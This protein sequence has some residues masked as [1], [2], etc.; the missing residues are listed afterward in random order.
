MVRRLVRADDLDA[1]LKPQVGAL[2]YGFACALLTWARER[3]EA[4]DT[5]AVEVTLAAIGLL[6]PPRRFTN[7]IHRV[8]R[9]VPLPDNTRHLADHVH[10]IAKSNGGSDAHVYALFQCIAE[11]EKWAQGN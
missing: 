11:L 2:H 3:A 10:G 4:N 6:D 9:D 7:E 1:E 5:S 8:R